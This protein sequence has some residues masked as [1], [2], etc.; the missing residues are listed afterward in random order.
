[1]VSRIVRRVVSHHGSDCSALAHKLRDSRC[2]VVERIDYPQ[3]R[4]SF[5]RVVGDKQEG[6]KAMKLREIAWDKPWCYGGGFWERVDIQSLV[7]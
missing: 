3:I 5:G 2:V 6:W 1:M 4:K 7:S